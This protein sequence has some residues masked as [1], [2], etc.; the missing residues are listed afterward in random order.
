MPGRGR[1]VLVVED[2]QL[3]S[4]LLADVLVAAGFEVEVANNV[5]DAREAVRAFDPDLALLDVSLGG[6]PSGL[7]LAI[8]LHASR[9]DIAL[10]FLT[11]HPD[12][13]TAGLDGADVPPGAGFLRKD[14]VT[15]T[16][17]LF[18]AIESVLAEQSGRVRH[19]LAPDRPLARLTAKQVDVLHMAAQ[20]LTNAAIAR[21]RHVSERSVEM[22]LHS[23][24]QTLGIATHGDVNPRVEAI[25]HY[26]VAAG[27]PERP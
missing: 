22:L 9:P 13:R 15:D 14:M 11:K 20:G 24:F 2:E 17:Y 23:V 26:I 19:D 18:D 5:L 16:A 25:R 3:M 6:G 21:E 8:V 1:R 4:S 10:I 27:M 12:R 7:D